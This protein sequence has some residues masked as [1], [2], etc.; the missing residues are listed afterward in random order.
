[1]KYYKPNSDLYLYV[2]GKYL[3]TDTINDLKKI[4][5]KTNDIDPESVNRGEIIATLSEMVFPMLKNENVF[6]S[7]LL[8]CDRNGIIETILGYL[9][10]IRTDNKNVGNPDPDI[11]ELSH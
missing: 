5:G 6:I 9:A 4:I 10:V 3:K 1:M 7:F 8:D 2:T 11:L